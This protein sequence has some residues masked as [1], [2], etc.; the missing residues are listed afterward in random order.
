M[1][2]V[3]VNLRSTVLKVALLCMHSTMASQKK[4]ARRLHIRLHQHTLCSYRYRYIVGPIDRCKLT[5]IT[6]LVELTNSEHTYSS[7]AASGQS[8]KEVGVTRAPADCSAF[9]TIMPKKLSNIPAEMC[10]FCVFWGSSRVMHGA[11]STIEC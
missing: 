5:A 10:I 4:T 1:P 3:V 11:D 2:I 8:L 7:H 6:V 9:V